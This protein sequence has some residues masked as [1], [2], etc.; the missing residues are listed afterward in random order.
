[1]SGPSVA[2][3]AHTVHDRG[4]MERA[5]AELI[6][7]T[8]DRFAF[9]LIASEVQEDLRHLVRWLPIRVPRRPVPLLLA[10]FWV[11]AGARLRDVD[12]DLVHTV[13]AIVP[14]RADIATVQFCHAAV[15]HLPQEM[16]GVDGGV[17]RQVNHAIDRRLALGMERHCYRERRIRMLA[18]ASSGVERELHE[19]YAGV[20]TTV[21]PNAVDPTR[22]RP[23]T[24]SRATVRAEHGYTDE[25]VV[26]VFLGGDWRRKGL[27]VVIEALAEARRR[28]ATRLRLLVVGRG[29]EVAAAAHAAAVGV[30]E[31]VTIAGP[32]LRPEALLAAGD[33]FVSA[34]SYEAFPLAALEAA[35]VG[36]PIVATP[37]NGIEELV[38]DGVGG[39]LCPRDPT[40]FGA[41]L[42]RL[43]ED[44]GLRQRMGA[45]VRTSA[46]AY[47]W[48]AVNRA[49]GEHYER[50]AAT[51]DDRPR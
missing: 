2:L 21:I 45:A 29:N 19:H 26:A 34:S 4:G 7:G 42:V 16:R 48:G 6:R 14:T 9:T 30:A 35:S 27:P 49:T 5:V 50:L 22:F 32:T 31:A 38:V 43:H 20:P 23:N 44:A 1:M 47:T 24:Q 41:A 3:V 12:A 13:G 46:A 28:G 25:D 15:A 40:S 37:I 33:V 17:A 10:G 51:S 39:L 36:L 11:A 8:A 18:A